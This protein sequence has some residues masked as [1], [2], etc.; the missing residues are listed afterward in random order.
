M[1]QVL[2]QVPKQL[3]ILAYSVVTAYRDYYGDGWFHSA[4]LS[5]RH[6]EVRSNRYATGRRR[7]WVIMDISQIFLPNPLSCA[8]EERVDQRSV[9][10]V[11]RLRHM[12]KYGCLKINSQ[13]FTVAA[14]SLA[15]DRAFAGYG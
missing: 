6:C 5:T 15:E 12:G 13:T 2:W 8:A 4:F 7:T 14:G 9:V 11:S 10:G 1:L 3:V